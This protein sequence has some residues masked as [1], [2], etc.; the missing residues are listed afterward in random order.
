MLYLSI[1]LLGQRPVVSPSFW[2]R[3]KAIAD[4][5]LKALIRKPFGLF[6][7]SWLIAAV[8]TLTMVTIRWRTLNP[9]EGQEILDDHDGFIL[10]FW[11]SRITAMPWLWPRRHA[12][13]ALQ[14][15][16]PDGRLLA[17]TVN[18]LGVRTVWG[19]SNRN[20]MSGLRGLKRVLDAGKVVAITP[21]G[22]RG[23]AR[24]SAVG[25]VALANLT[26]KS[27]VP[28]AWAVDRF[29]RAPGWDG[30]II[31]KPFCRGVMVWG[32]ELLPGLAVAGIKKNGDKGNRDRMES[33]RQELEAALNDVTDR[34]DEF[35]THEKKSDRG[36]VLNDA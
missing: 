27:I 11:H 6:V 32:E 18:H 1:A 3:P 33:Q 26:K 34:A 13:N 30:M 29:W 2:K 14:S 12:M 16:H 36:K 23:P 17:H 25:P 22:P 4:T 15:P 5:M 24:I 9:K 8:V 31:P 35:F 28:V 20:A 21:D 7:L 10:V 19:S